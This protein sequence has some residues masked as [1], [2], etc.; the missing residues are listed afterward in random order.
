MGRDIKSYRSS[1][2]H[3]FVQGA[4]Q[5]VHLVFLQVLLVLRFN[6]NDLGQK[7]AVFAPFLY[8]DVPIGCMK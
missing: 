1:Q 8:G 5:N 4:N 2:R 6:V 3:V 7:T